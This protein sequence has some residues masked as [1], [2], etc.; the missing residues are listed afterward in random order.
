MRCSAMLALVSPQSCSALVAGGGSGGDSYLHQVF[1]LRKPCCRQ[2]GWDRVRKSL[3]QREGGRRERCEG[4]VYS[5][6]A[7]VT[8][9]QKTISCFSRNELAGDLGMLSL[10]L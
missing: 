6:T 8:Y 9:A 5:H 1:I 2:L 4:V 7:G 10:V 3:Y